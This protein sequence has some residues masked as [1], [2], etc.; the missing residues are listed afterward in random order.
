MKVHADWLNSSA[1]TCVSDVLTQSGFQAWFVGGCVRNAL[2]G[3]P[4][5]DLDISTNAHPDQVMTLAKQAGLNVIPTGI[6]H[7]TVTVICE[8]QPFEITTF[9]LDVET[10]G[11]RAVVAFADS[12]HED[13]QRR[14][15]TMNALY[16]DIQGEIV[17]PVGGLDDLERRMFRFIGNAEDRIKEDYLRILR[18]FRFHAWYGHPMNGI[19]ADGLAACAMHIEGLGTLSAERIGTEIKKLLSA[20][21]PSP[22]V[23]SFASIGG[24][25]QVLPGADHGALAVLVHLEGDRP[26]DPIRRL[27]CLGGEDVA[28]AFR[29]SNSEKRMLDRIAEAGEAD[30]G[31][32]ELGYRFPDVAEDVHLIRSA[33]MGTS[34]DPSDFDAIERG[35]QQVFPVKAN[36]LMPDYSG[37]ALGAML[38]TLEDRWIVSDFTLSKEQLLSTIA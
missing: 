38:R 20:L 14:D 11:R 33:K 18:F 19:D 17:D 9:R 25:A 15:F 10:D 5:S 35:K 30:L 29:L 34:I 12:L 31:L 23:A 21:D 22:A 26:V 16:A 4:V 13:A 1:A 3:A 36:D 37:P 2:L 6:D 32:A 24:L 27:A 28:K 8:G 7:G